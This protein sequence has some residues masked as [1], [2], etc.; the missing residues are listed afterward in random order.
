MQN[1][2]AHIIAQG[3]FQ[4]PETDYDKIFFLV[5]KFTILCLFLTLVAIFDLEIVRAVWKQ[6]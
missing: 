5:A 2:K 3:F 1:T 6:C 4:I